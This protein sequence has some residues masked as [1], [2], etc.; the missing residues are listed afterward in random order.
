MSMSKPLRAAWTE[1]FAIARD[2]GAGYVGTDMLLM[3][4]TRTE[5]AAAEVLA[6]AGATEAAVAAIVT[7]TNR[8]GAMPADPEAECGASAPES[9]GARSTGS[10]GRGH[11]HRSRRRRRIEIRLLLALTYDRDGIHSSLLRRVGIDRGVLVQALADGGVRVP[12]RPPP[13]DRTPHFQLWVTLPDHQARVVAAKNWRAARPRTWTIGSTRGAA[14]AGDTAASRAG[15]V[16]ARIYGEER[17]DL[18]TLV[19]EILA[20]S[21]YP[22]PPDDSWETHREV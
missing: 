7:P 3:G 5:G 20:A 1:A 9:R 12:P 19:P 22:P 11:R 21:G 14:P 18:P 4:L 10:R 16:E 6:A 15:P 17:I 13:P 2:L 8:A